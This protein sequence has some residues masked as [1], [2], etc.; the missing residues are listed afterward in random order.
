MRF[1]AT[2]RLIEKKLYRLKDLKKRLEN[3]YRS[4]ESNK[5]I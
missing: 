3:A 2:E 1:S 4:K 5:S